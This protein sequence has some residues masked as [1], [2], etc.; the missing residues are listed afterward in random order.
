MLYYRITRLDAIK[1]E[2]KKMVTSYCSLNYGIP[3][4]RPESKRGRCWSQS[5]NFQ[6]GVG[7][8]VGVARNS[9]T[10]QPYI[11]V[12]HTFSCL[13]KW[14]TEICVINQRIYF[15]LLSGSRPKGERRMHFQTC[16]FI[17]STLYR[18]IF[19]PSNT[20]NLDLTVIRTTPP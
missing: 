16:T 6:A 9:S 18:R 1:S 14:Q 4:V 10:P 17:I 3:L 19:T 12:L 20:T 2:I 7:V 15:F 8:G 5:Q 11:Q 13:S